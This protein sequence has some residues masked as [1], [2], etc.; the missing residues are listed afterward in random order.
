MT[1]HI[2]TIILVL[3]DILVYYTFLKTVLKRK[4]EKPLDYLL[5][6]LY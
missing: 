3:T 4:S 1:A 6:F 2:I 5:F